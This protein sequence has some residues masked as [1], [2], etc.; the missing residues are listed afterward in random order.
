VT[1]QEFES[2]I[3]NDNASI[4]IGVN[5]NNTGSPVLIDSRR[6]GV[7]NDVEFMVVAIMVADICECLAG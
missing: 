1:P 4:S 2:F 5:I 7:G 6:P 3:S